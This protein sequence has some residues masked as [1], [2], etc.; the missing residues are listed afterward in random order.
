MDVA[1]KRLL[2][3]A[4]G[5]ALVLL[6]TAAAFSAYFRPDMIATFADAWALCAS[7]VR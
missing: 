7:L 3:K 1:R 2:F 5:V 4:G 6:V